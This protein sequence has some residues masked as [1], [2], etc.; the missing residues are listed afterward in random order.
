M[1]VEKVEANISDQFSYLNGLTTRFSGIIENLSTLEWNSPLYDDT[2][3]SYDLTFKAVKTVDSPA[4]AFTIKHSATGDFIDSMGEGDGQNGTLS[5]SATATYGTIDKASGSQDQKIVTKLDKNGDVVSSTETESSK[6]SVTSSNN[7]LDDKSDDY[8]H[9]TSS[10]ESDSYVEKTG[11]ESYAYKSSD[12]YKSKDLN[13][14]DSQDRKYGNGNGSGS[15]KIASTKI[16]FSNHNLDIQNTITANSAFS[17][18]YSY[19]DNGASVSSIKISAAEFKIAADDKSSLSSLNFSGEMT[20]VSSISGEMNEVAS[21]NI[22]NFTLE[23]ADFKFVSGAVKTVI[24]SEDYS[25]IKGQIRPMSITDVFTEENINSS[26]AIFQGFNQGDNTITIKNVDGASVDGGNGADTIIGGSGNDGITGGA[27]S[28]KLTGDK[29]T[30]TFSFSRSDFF[31]EKVN[32][33][34]DS[35]ETFSKSVDTIADFNLKD[36]DILDLG[37]LGELTFYATLA[38]AKADDASLFY[39]NGAIYLN[40]DMT[41]NKYTA[42]SVI[43]LTGNPKVNADFTGFD[44]PVKTEDGSGFVYTGTDKADVIVAESGDDLISG[45][46]GSDKLTGGTGTDTFSFS[47]SDFFTE[48]VNKNGDSVETFSKSVDTITDFNLKDFDVLDLGEALGKLGFYATLADAKTYEDS[49]FY[50]DGMIYLNTDITGNKYTPTAIINLTGNPKVNADFTGFDYPVKT[51]DGNG[52]VYTGT[53]AAD[54][55]VA[56]L[57]DDLIT[58]GAGSDKLTGGKGVDTFSFSRSDFFTET[59]DKNGDSVETFSKSIDTITDF[60]LK[61]GDDLD[62]N[63]LGELTFYKTLAEAKADDA[64]LVYVKGVIYLNTG[65]DD[66][67]IATAIINLTGNPAVNTDFTGFDYPN[68]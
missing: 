14:S 61:D 39:F 28:D 64:S 18:S 25:A 30:D 24:S 4:G 31:T 54:V 15:T 32:K 1:A 38:E 68:Y 21:V 16:A 56:E 42:T 13:Y 57:G 36:G 47:R 10:S 50:V 40:T 53:N 22:K 19:I 26:I 65:T 60:N 23:T 11:A 58:G 35:V 9:T 51:A 6:T 27:G 5:N 59:V 46:A 67:Y 52:L 49:L 44:Y 48:K 3:P 45:G 66:K 20:E 17:S 34:G 7:T 12:V 2:K 43:T 8:T 37:D 33:N 41:G 63:D 29:G 55:I 62:L